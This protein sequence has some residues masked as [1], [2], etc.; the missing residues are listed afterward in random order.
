MIKLVR[1]GFET[2]TDIRKDNISYELL[3][4]L[5]LAFSMFH[6]KDASLSEYRNKFSVR[7]ENLER[8]YGVTTLPGDT[9]IT[10]RESIDEVNHMA[11][12]GLFKPQL[13]Y[14]K[15]AGVIENRRVLGK[16]TAILVDGAGHYCSGKS[17]CPQFMVKNHRNGKTTYYHQ[18]LGAV[19][20]HPQ[21]ST[22]FSVACNPLSNK[23]AVLQRM[24]VN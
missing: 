8:V 2:L 15:S 21:Q 24:T 11:L 19:A 23:I 6:L 22:V 4:Y 18:L 16:Y 1:T 7:A 9:T 13:D 5:N 17:G 12:Q 10:I 20:A 3:S 14:L